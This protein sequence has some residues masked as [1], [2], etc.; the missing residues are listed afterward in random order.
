MKPAA[1]LGRI[2]AAATVS[3]LRETAPIVSSKDVF[4]IEIQP[5]PDA[6]AYLLPRI[7]NPTGLS[8]DT[9]KKIRKAK[10]RL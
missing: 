8:R 3:T 9:Q 6:G 7:P 10:K 1:T 5:P 4:E 2:F